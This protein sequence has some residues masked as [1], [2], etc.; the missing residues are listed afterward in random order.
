MTAAAGIRTAVAYRTS[1]IFEDGPHFLEIAHQLEAGAFDQALAHPYHPL[2]PAMIALVHSV[3]PDWEVAALFVSILGGTIS[4]AALYLFL[5]D[6]FDREAAIFGACLLAVSPYAV[7]FTSDIESEGPYLALLISGVACLWR[8]L[9]QQ[10]AGV[11]FVAGSLSGLAY[12]TRPEGLGLALVGA[13]L[14]GV[15]WCQ[16][17][18]CFGRAVKATGALLAGVALA[19]APY[20]WVLHELRG[21]WVLSGKKSP[22]RILGLTGE[23]ANLLQSDLGNLPLLAGVFLALISLATAVAWRWRGR[24]EFRA[25]RSRRLGTGLVLIGLAIWWTFWPGELKEFF[26]VAIST[27]R[28]EVAVLVAIGLIPLLTREASE[29]SPEE[30]R[31]RNQF[32]LIF[33][34]AYGVVLLGLL[35]N[36]GYLSRRHALPL[37]PFAL[38][39]AGLG[40]SR[41]VRW[42]SERWP[43]SS[44]AA[45]AGR[46][47]AVLGA[48]LLTGLVAI[49][50][51][52]TLRDHREDV[53]AQ[54][55]AAEWLRDQS[56]PPGR[57]ASNKR[58]IG[59]YYAARD[60]VPLM[61]ESGI[62]SL[63]LLAREQ[64]RY[65]VVDD[66]V[67]GSWDAMKSG[68]GIQLRE[69]YRV[70]R[71]NRRAMVYELAPI[72]P[73]SIGSGPPP[74][75]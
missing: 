1:A 11:A 60:W 26:G 34:L 16:G 46:P 47:A 35:F 57:V 32:L 33:L 55:A 39:H 50:L 64:V 23:S 66:K 38:G 21:G 68:K 71:G 24:S 7:R 69:L 3:V 19:S 54:R 51:P 58:R 53:R 31:A 14:I 28:P 62:R 56:M 29:H 2:Y 40:A 72:A 61:A 36:H 59:H 65:I 70:E 41:L 8:A 27:L 4:V 43:A 63:D 22:L 45:V 44:L 74:P 37:V 18:W 9:R 67:L 12:L 48:L 42:G 30:E 49:A 15:Q 6:A 52:K 20:L 75:G 73:P 25:S 13:V 17:R 5:R 10:R